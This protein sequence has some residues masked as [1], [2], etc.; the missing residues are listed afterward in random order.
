MYNALGFKFK[1]PPVATL[2]TSNAPV[3]SFKNEGLVEAFNS[4]IIGA[5]RIAEAFCLSLHKKVNSSLFKIPP[6]SKEPN[7]S[8]TYLKVI[9]SLSTNALPKPV[10]GLIAPSKSAI[11]LS[12]CDAPSN[13]NTL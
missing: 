3:N 13:G 12:D 10:P 5:L 11:N 9:L 6:F 7:V 4:L 2:F 8:I 1:L